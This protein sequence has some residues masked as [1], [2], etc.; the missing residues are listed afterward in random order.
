MYLNFSYKKIKNYFTALK[1]RALVLDLT[2]VIVN[3]FSFHYDGKTIIVKRN[4]I[5]HRLRI[6]RKAL[7]Y[8]ILAYILVDLLIACLLS[9]VRKLFPKYVASLDEYGYLTRAEYLVKFA[10]MFNVL[11]L[12][13]SFFALAHWLNKNNKKVIITLLN[14]MLKMRQKLNK[15]IAIDL[16][17]LPPHCNILFHLQFLLIIWNLLNNMRL[18]M[19][20]ED[21]LAIAMDF[22]IDLY[23]V[24]LYFMYQIVL[25]IQWNFHDN[26]NMNFEKRMACKAFKYKDILRFIALLRRLKKIQH[27]FAKCL[28]WFPAIVILKAFLII[29]ESSF[30]WIYIKQ[31][32]NLAGIRLI[33]LYSSAALCWLDVFL[34]VFMLSEMCRLDHYA[35]HL[36]FITAIRQCEAMPDDRGIFK[37]V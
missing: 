4:R 30:L 31:H 10:F 33:W 5:N 15:P 32:H 1:I 24:S 22:I 35:R 12:I 37:E 19:K 6:V 8:A 14:E 29:T 18:L 25:L 21:L 34:L 9:I 13:V 11:K 2:L 23:Y 26:L 28:V 3:I 17:K 20:I 16:N 36:L 7:T 27:N